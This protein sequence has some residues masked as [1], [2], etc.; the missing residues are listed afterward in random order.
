MWWT[1]WKLKLN[2]TCYATPAEGLADRFTKIDRSIYG[3]IPGITDKGFYTNSYHVP[4]DYPIS[5]FEKMVIEGR[6]HK[7]CNA[8]RIS[9]IELDGEPTAD[10]I[11]QIVNHAFNSGVYYIGINYVMRY[12][13]D[14]GKKIHNGAS[15][16]ECGSTKYKV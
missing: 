13:K 12:C 6:F 10:I 14:C 2:F 15:K 3:E 7:L 8:G 4:V 11:E 16:C 5:T 9:Y 1:N